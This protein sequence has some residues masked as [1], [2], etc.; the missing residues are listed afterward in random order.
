M[1]EEPKRTKGD[2]LFRLRRGCGVGGVPRGSR[3]G[4]GPA[5]RRGCRK[6]RRGGSRS[7]RP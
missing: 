7:R 2:G 4:D 3:G 5:R 1:L 6:S